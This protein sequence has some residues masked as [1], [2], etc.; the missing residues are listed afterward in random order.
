MV[1]LFLSLH[2]QHL[3]ACYMSKMPVAVAHIKDAKPSC[4]CLMQFHKPEYARKPIVQDTFY[5]RTTAFAPQGGVAV[6][7]SG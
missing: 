3:R 4:A 6:A 2:K 7:A 5:R 1:H